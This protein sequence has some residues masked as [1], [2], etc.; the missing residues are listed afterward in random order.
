MLFQH[1]HTHT[2]H[3]LTSPLQALSGPHSPTHILS[4]DAFAARLTTVSPHTP[5]QPHSLL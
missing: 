2:R 4:F 3:A 5:Q 1:T